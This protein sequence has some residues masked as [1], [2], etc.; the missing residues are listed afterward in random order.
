ML[1]LS[2]QL[3]CDRYHQSNYV[4][5]CYSVT[6]DSPEIWQIAN[7]YDE[8]LAR[9]PDEIREGVVQRMEASGVPGSHTVRGALL[10]ESN[11]FPS[12]IEDEKQYRRKK[13]QKLG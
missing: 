1:S 7:E 12:L 6:I 4:R 13:R 2:L 3:G 9:V 10:N 8:C 5:D 11:P